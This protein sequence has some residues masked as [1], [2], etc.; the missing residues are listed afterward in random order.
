MVYKTINKL[1]GNYDGSIVFYEGF[2]H[3][4]QQMS[5]TNLDDAKLNLNKQD[6]LKYQRR[7]ELELN[8]VKDIRTVLNM[9]KGSAH[10]SSPSSQ[11]HQPPHHLVGAAPFG[12]PMA[13]MGS[14]FGGMGGMG[15]MGSPYYGGLNNDPYEMPE[16]DPDVW[17]PPPPVNKY[18]PNI[19]GGGG[20]G[21]IPNYNNMYPSPK[22]RDYKGKQVSGSDKNSKPVVGKGAAPANGANPRRVSN[23]R[24]SNQ[25]VRNLFFNL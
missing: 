20:G 2:L 19:I 11:H 8:Q 3:E 5:Q 1:I 16:R 10:M 22:N 25:P 4:L 9:F 6:L 7:V 13:G 24:R 21:G 17:P 15:G 23:D 14:P 12:S 18:K